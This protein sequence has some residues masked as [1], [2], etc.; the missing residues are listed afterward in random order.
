MPWGKSPRGGG[1][2]GG[3]TLLY[4]SY[5]YVLP[6]SDWYGFCVILVWDTPTKNSEECPPGGEQHNLHDLCSLC[7]CF[8]LKITS[9]TYLYFPIKVFQNSVR[10]HSCILYQ[11]LSH[12]FLSRPQAI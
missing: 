1:V 10:Y 8:G 6:Q 7:Q 2:G 9:N 3:G 11:A 12:F 4:K 5:R